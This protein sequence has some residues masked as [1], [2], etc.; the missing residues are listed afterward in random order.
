[1][2]TT[3]EQVIGT[4]NHLL[5][6]CIGSVQRF[7][8]A[9]D[10]VTDGHLKSLLKQYS[11]Q[12]ERMASE[13]RM[14]VRLLGG[15]PEGIYDLATPLGMPRFSYAKTDEEDRVIIAE[16]ERDEAVAVEAYRSALDDTN[17]PA[18]LRKRLLHHSVQVREAHDRILALGAT[19]VTGLTPNRSLNSSPSC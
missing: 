17:I 3:N 14:E 18:E 4:L 12:R 11:H 6:I 9:A 15:E 1:M 2:A 10:V 7:R 13:L 19:V 16:C 8:L 5:A